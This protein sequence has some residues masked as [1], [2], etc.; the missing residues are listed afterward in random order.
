MS[1]G[2]K[3]AYRLGLTPWERAAEE[4]QEQLDALLDKLEVGRT[5][6]LGR[7]LDIGCGT[8]RHTHDLARRGWE[9]TGV[10][11]VPLAIERA[12]ARGGDASFVCGDVTGLASLGLEPFDFFLD[13]GCLHVFDRTRR[14]AISRQIT[15]LARPGAQMLLLAFQPNTI[16]FVPEGISQEEIEE[17]FADWLLVASEPADVE[18]MPKPLRK[19]APQFYSLHLR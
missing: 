4:G 7:A 2:W 5:P 11:F 13:I 9:A 15:G 10:D 17:T 18:G 19:T 8:G 3:L 12:R 1:L 6:P 14:A 16:P